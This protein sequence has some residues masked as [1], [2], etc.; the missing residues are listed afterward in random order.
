[1][2]IVIHKGKKFVLN[3][4]PEWDLR[5]LTTAIRF[6]KGCPHC[7]RCKLGRYCKVGGPF[8]NWKRAEKEGFLEGIPKSITR[9][10][11][12]HRATFLTK[13]RYTPIYKKKLSIRSNLIKK[14]NKSFIRKEKLFMSTVLPLI[15]NSSEY[16]LKRTWSKAQKKTLLSLIKKYPKGKISID[17]VKVVSDPL[18]KT[19]PHPGNLKLLRSYYWSTTKVMSPQ[20]LKRK[21]ADAVRYKHE[22]YK[23]HIESQRKRRKIVKDSVNEFLSTKL[24]LRS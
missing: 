20:R 24:E 21:R 23:E 8:I 16:K 3:W 13:V 14:P 19:L 18:C 4:K 10:E 9:H 15:K 11:L 5:I 1:M 12:S 7:S 22:H 17:W 6:R 2:P